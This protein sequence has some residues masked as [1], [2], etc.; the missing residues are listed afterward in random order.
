MNQLQERQMVNPFVTNLLARVCLVMI[1]PLAVFPSFTGMRPQVRTLCK[2]RITRFDFQPQSQQLNLKKSLRFWS[3][4]MMPVA[5]SGDK[6][7]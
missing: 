2:R 3:S 5:T 6:R 7:P 1:P 4:E